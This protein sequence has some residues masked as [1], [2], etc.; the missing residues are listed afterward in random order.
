MV[1]YDIVFKPLNPAEAQIRV[2]RLDP[3]PDI[4][5]WPA[6]QLD[7]K[8]LDDGVEYDAVSYAW[9]GPQA[10]YPL[11]LG[12]LELP[13][14]ETLCAALRY[15]RHHSKP[16]YL[17]LDAVCI[18]Q[19]NLEE[20]AHQ[21]ALM[22]RIFHA[23][24]TVC[25]WLGHGSE[26][27]ECVMDTMRQFGDELEKHGRARERYDVFPSLVN[28]LRAASDGLVEISR[29]SFWNRLW[30]IQEITLARKLSVYHGKI[31]LGS[32]IMN[33]HA[34]HE[35][36]LWETRLPS[37]AMERAVDLLLRLTFLQGKVAETIALPVLEQARV[38]LAFFSRARTSIATD[39]RDR[40]YGLLGIC[41]SYFGADFMHADYT[42]SAATV[43]T[44]FALRF[45][46]SSGSLLLLTQATPLHNALSSLPSWVPDWSSFY[47][48]KFQVIH[49][50]RWKAYRAF[51][52]EGGFTNCL[53]DG[54]MLH[55]KGVL[56]STVTSVG[57]VYYPGHRH[58]FHD[59]VLTQLSHDQTIESWKTLYEEQ[60]PPLLHGHTSRSSMRRSFVRTVLWDMN[61]S[62]RRP[63]NMQTPYQAIAE[64]SRE[65]ERINARGLDGMLSP[66]R[67]ELAE[68]NRE[69]DR[70]TALRLD[71][72]LSPDRGEHDHTPLRR[73]ELLGNLSAD[74]ALS[75]IERGLVNNRFFIT[76]KGAPG[77]G[78]RNARPGDVVAVLDGANMPFLLRKESTASQTN[79]YRLVGVCYVHGMLDGEAIEEAGP[80]AIE[81][82][83]LK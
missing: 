18:S 40:V 41:A 47:D 50:A 32:Q 5:A 80:G 48:H 78:P 9:E 29:A 7:I 49:L 67:G 12:A 4:D 59:R 13:I 72:M 63:D 83:I 57:E 75:R 14:S 55:L 66:D 23:A 65:Y 33:K 77:M 36:L 51:P 28:Q 79:E 58:P 44:T 71:G 38:V 68:H 39:P 73:H 25:V 69:Y 56:H 17:W 21:V 3:N 22:R 62:L 19:R 46:E 8:S 64:P 52:H 74:R 53:V 76:S 60:E 10:T 37:D 81:D 34:L 2:L 45:I 15:L 1:E 54:N 16:R 42:I 82:I 11:F 35:L 24:S 26:V 43:Y 20:R 31:R 61:P 30:I 27:V 70:I 6:G